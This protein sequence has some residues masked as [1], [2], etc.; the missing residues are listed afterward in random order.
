LSAESAICASSKAIVRRR[1]NLLLL[2]TLAGDEHHIARFRRL[3][4]NANRRR[5]IRLDGVLDAARLQPRLNLRQDRLGSSERG[6]SLVATTKSLP[7]PRPA[8]SWAAWCG[9]DR[10]R[11]RTA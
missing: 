6:L 7:V 4:R 1:E 10:R 9:R 5:A 11:S 8:P 3:Q 2:V